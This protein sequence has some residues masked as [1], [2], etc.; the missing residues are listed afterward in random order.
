M[1]VKV[2]RELIVVACTFAL[3][4]CASGGASQSVSQSD[5]DAIARA[6]AHTDLGAAYYQQNKLEIALDEFNEALRAEPNFALAH[7]GLGLVYAALK[8]DAKAE[9]SFKRSVQ[10]D[11]N[12]SESH[13]NYGSFLCSR[14]R[15]DEFITQFLDAVRNPLYATPQLAY[16]NAGLCSLKKK[17]EK[18]AEV[19]FTKALQV[20]PLLHRAA[21]QLAQL[22]FN[23]GDALR[24]RNTLQTA[25]FSQPTPEILWLGIQIERSLGNKDAEASYGLELRKRY[26]D[27]PQTQLLLNGQ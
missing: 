19:Y 13:N 20:D 7:N 9:A 24:A 11:A 26:P 23:Q 27:S 2:W 5:R 15:I 6:R 4:A 21:Y 17:D 10:I 14:G 25:I 3:V 18:N 16:T 22:K 8:E 1:F 12:S